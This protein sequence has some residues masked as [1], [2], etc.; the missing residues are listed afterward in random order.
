MQFP[1]AAD[2]E[3]GMG[4]LVYYHGPNVKPSGFHPDVKPLNLPIVSEFGD[5]NE[6]AKIPTPSGCIYSPNFQI[7]SIT[8]ALEDYQYPTP[9]G[10]P[11][12]EYD[13]WGNRIN[14]DYTLTFDRYDDIFV[15]H[16]FRFL[17]PVYLD[18]AEIGVQS[19]N[20]IG[21][22]LEDPFAD[23]W[24]NASEL[25][26]AASIRYSLN[27]ALFKDVGLGGADTT[28]NKTIY[29]CHFV[30][31]INSILIDITLNWDRAYPLAFKFNFVT[32]TPPFAT[33]CR[34]KDSFAVAGHAPICEWPDRSSTYV[35]GAVAKLY[36]HGPKSP[37][38]PALDYR[39]SS[40]LKP[41]EPSAVKI[42]DYYENLKHGNSGF[43]PVIASLWYQGNVGGTYGNGY[44]PEEPISD[45]LPINFTPLEPSSGK[46]FYERGWE[47][48][49]PSLFVNL[50]YSFLDIDENQVLFNHSVLDCRIPKGIAASKD[51]DKTYRDYLNR[52][53]IYKMRFQFILINKT[54]NAFSRS[55]KLTGRGRF[56]LNGK[57]YYLNDTEENIIEH[58][59]R[60]SGQTGSYFYAAF[61]SLDINNCSRDCHFNLSTGNNIECVDIADN[62]FTDPN[63]PRTPYVHLCRSDIL[64]HW[65]KYDEES[66]DFR[67]DNLGGELTDDH[68]FEVTFSD[69]TD[70]T[71]L[72]EYQYADV[73][74][75]IVV[76]SDGDVKF[77]IDRPIQSL[78]PQNVFFPFYHGVRGS[79][80]VNGTTFTYTGSPQYILESHVPNAVLDA[81]VTNVGKYTYYGII[82]SAIWKYL[83]PTYLEILPY[84]LT[85]SSTGNLD[86]TFDGT[87]NHTPPVFSLGAVNNPPP[88]LV[89]SVRAFVADISLTQDEVNNYPC[90]PEIEEVVDPDTGEHLY[91]RSFYRSPAEVP[92]NVTADY[93]YKPYAGSDNYE[94]TPSKIVLK[95][96]KQVN[97]IELLNVNR[98]DDLHY[99]SNNPINYLKPSPPLLAATDPSP[100]F[101]NISPAGLV[102]GSVF[103]E[104]DARP[105]IISEVQGSQT[106]YLR[107]YKGNISGYIKTVYSRDFIGTFNYPVDPNKPVDPPVSFGSGLAGLM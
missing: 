46:K 72:G 65:S 29:N 73:S 91:D 44:D 89:F 61:Q 18:V 50:S 2:L 52:D 39:L 16:K 47:G 14:T 71:P 106:Q 80:P 63:A 81:G 88:D 58:D 7:S 86:V 21:F 42:I 54:G 8:T 33:P 101:V 105:L 76:G 93:I 51:L 34:L 100:L 64:G 62:I 48:P 60:I 67:M 38:T 40:D 70:G 103:G 37:S 83:Y 3:P 10:S 69:S 75:G 32:P 94:F 11:I 45:V 68:N 26:L 13:I 24:F 82:S 90:P 107:G 6:I 22:V 55:I 95:V 1:T 30:R 15:R 4:A 104:I 66:K 28:Y 79:I 36:Y 85:W 87:Q 31:G 98:I 74:P 99:D 23:G 57:L 59:I 43:K 19:G 41:G 96:R 49:E 84:Q 78:H 9:G 97:S 27:G 25:N 12:Q 92:I 53:S 102:N 56:W 5:L 35:E 17:I 77:K 20:D